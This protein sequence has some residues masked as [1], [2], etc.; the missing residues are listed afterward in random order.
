M[1][2]AGRLNKVVQQVFESTGRRDEDEARSAVRVIG[3]R[4]RYSS[5]KKNEVPGPEGERL[6][7]HH[8]RERAINDIDAFILAMMDVEREVD[9]EPVLGERVGTAGI[10]AERL[11]LRR[12]LRYPRGLASTTADEEGPTCLHPDHR[13][14][15]ETPSR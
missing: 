15:R 13:Y 3:Q 4:M 12:R 11:V 1:A 14:L 6:L 7:T 5:E 8:G 2:V 10:D 9:G